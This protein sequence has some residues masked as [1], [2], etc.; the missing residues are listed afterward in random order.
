MREHTPQLPLPTIEGRNKSSDWF[1]IDA[2]RYIV[3]LFT[4]EARHQY[5]LETLWKNIPADPLLELEA[6]DIDT[7]EMEQ[8]IEGS[9]DNAE[10][11][12]NGGNEAKQMVGGG[13]EAECM[14]GG[15]D[16]ME[17]AL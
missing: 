8:G 3:H 5:D 4:P 10:R 1:L 13:G 6:Q 12:L 14:V 2:G 11:V 9:R 16:K 15:E 7:E 17:R